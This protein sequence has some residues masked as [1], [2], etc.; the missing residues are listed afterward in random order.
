[1]D[2][3]IREVITE[4]AVANDLE[5]VFLE[6]PGLPYRDEALNITQ[7][8]IKAYDAKFPVN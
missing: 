3:I 8:I 5:I 6:Y 4:Y 1:M 2:E 7:E